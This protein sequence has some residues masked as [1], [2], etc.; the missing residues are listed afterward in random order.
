MDALNKTNL[1]TT[2]Y[3][4][5]SPSSSILRT[6]TDIFL[7]CSDPINKKRIFTEY[8]SN[9]HNNTF[10]FRGRVFSDSKRENSQKLSVQRIFSRMSSPKIIL[11]DITSLDTMSTGTCM[12][13]VQGCSCLLI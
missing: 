1:M 6:F 10:S 12:L 2:V 7:F 11:E 3:R 8:N 4:I 13:N 9:M 5:F